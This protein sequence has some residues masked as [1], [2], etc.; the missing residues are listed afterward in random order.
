MNA[1]SF[2]TF[3]IF[4]NYPELICAF[5][6]RMGGLSTGKLSSLNLGFNTTDSPNLV[7]SNR[8]LFYKALQISKD[9]IAFQDQ[10]HSPNVKY[11]LRPGMYSNTDA[12]ICKTRG[13]FL[14]IQTADCFPV[15]LY[16]AAIKLVAIIHVGW[17]GAISGI[18]DNTLQ[19][20]KTDHTNNL[21]DFLVTIG[22][23]L[24]AE[25]FEVKEEV[26]SQFP[27]K[28]LR[29][30]NDKQKRYLN[31]KD[32]I[33]YKLLQ[34]GILSSNIYIYPDCT[35]CNGSHFYSYRRDGQHSGRMMGII[36]MK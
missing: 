36:G 26:Y 9:H 12:L 31:L 20:I 21:A 10:T 7:Q 5:S 28:F 32:Y 23:G 8:H 22:P 17:R 27:E 6:T 24:N 16:S 4:S 15:F 29:K 19:V 33:I 1:K 35:K 3:K 14:A 18:I 13:I 2:I 11:V 30:H 34:F 25:C